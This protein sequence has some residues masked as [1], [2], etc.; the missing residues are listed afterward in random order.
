MKIK[1]FIKSFTCEKSYIDIFLDESKPN[2]ARFDSK[3]GY[4]LTNSIMRDGVDNSFTISNYES[5]GERRKVNYAHNSC[6]INTYGNSFTQCHQVSDGETWQEYLAAH[7]AEPIQNFGIGGYGVYQAYLRMLRHEANPE[8]A[9][10]YILLNI[11]SDDHFRSI[12][13]WR[14]IRIDMF[15]QEIKDVNPNYF[16]ANPWNYVRI[17]PDTL[18]FEEYPSL[19]PTRE[20]LYNLCNEEYLYEQFRDDIVVHLEQAKK[21]FEYDEKVIRNAA[22]L[23]GVTC[24]FSDADA[25]AS[26]ATIVHNTYALK[27]SEYILE[28]TNE[29]CKASDKKLMVILSHGAP[30]MYAGI[31]GQ[32][33]FDE[34]LVRYLKQSNYLYVDLI[35]SH[36]VDFRKYNIT[37]KEYIQ[38]Y[39]IYGVGHYN[40]QG[41][42]FCAFALK[43]Q[44]VDM[45]CP[46]PVTYREDSSAGAA[47]LASRLA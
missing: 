44:L 18:M 14:W 6:R 43:D 22:D 23:V 2:W 27:S 11:F 28:K 5:T 45:L 36:T 46:K 39:Y 1:E 9:A 8:Q 13:R 19:C 17:N 34:S 33:R 31:T 47:L 7:L 40:P 29:F 32:K 3:L 38:K 20:S 30:E 12:D 24:D 4:V 16:H 42:H 26:T 37:P 35:D 21:G 25:A 41:N 15:R 10:Q